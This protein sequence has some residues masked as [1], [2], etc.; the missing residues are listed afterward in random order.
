MSTEQSELLN[1]E[2]KNEGEQDE[3]GDEII[4]IIDCPG[5]DGARQRTNQG[6]QRIR[7]RM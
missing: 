4:E 3:N 5:I 1:D 6:G 7:M 2:K